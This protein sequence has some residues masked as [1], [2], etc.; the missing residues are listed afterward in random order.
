MLDTFVVMPSSSLL[1]SRVFDISPGQPGLALL[2]DKYKIY[3]AAQAYGNC[4]LERNESWADLSVLDQTQ[5]VL[6]Y[7]KYNKWSQSLWDYCQLTNLQGNWYCKWTLPWN[8]AR[9]EALALALSDG[10]TKQLYLA[11]RIFDTY[12]EFESK[13]KDVI[14]QT[15]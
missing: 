9:W 2:M 5:Y 13:L 14:H 3:W 8:L 7:Y 1:A 11:Y 10:I 6:E 12:E 15:S 4:M